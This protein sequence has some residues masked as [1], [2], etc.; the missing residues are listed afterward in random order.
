MQPVQRNA[1]Y[2]MYDHFFC[3]KTERPQ[4]FRK[5]IMLHALA[6]DR[7]DHHRAQHRHYK[8]PVEK[9]TIQNN[10]YIDQAIAKKCDSLKHQVE[11]VMIG[12]VDDNKT[13]SLSVNQ[14]KY[15]CGNENSR[16]NGN[17]HTKKWMW[18]GL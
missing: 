16:T 11:Y 5:Y 7:A 10:G 1:F 4:F 12:T 13:A 18:V 3:F 14:K 15:H 8:M 17:G 6:Q 2:F 9:N